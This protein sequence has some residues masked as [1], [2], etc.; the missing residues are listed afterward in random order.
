MKFAGRFIDARRIAP[1]AVIVTFMVVTIGHVANYAGSFEAPGWL[2]L[3]WP[4]ALAVD[5]AIIICSYFTKWATTERW[6]WAGYLSFTLASGVMNAAAIQPWA[7]ANPIPAWVYAE[8]PTV[9]IA[10][11][12]FLYR[13]IDKLVAS[14]ERKHSESNEESSERKPRAK[15]RKPN[16]SA[17]R[18]QIKELITQGQYQS[19]EKLAP[20]F[21]VSP[22]TIRN[23]VRLLAQTGEIERQDNRWVA[24]SNGSG[25]EG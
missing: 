12:G 2:W 10:L 6:A 1:L 15:R 8:F 13:S 5:V 3:G 14:K 9:A 17:R 25:A 7:K 24:A 23:D 18:A 20:T 22:Q 11:L 16:A 21:G 19:S 4:Y